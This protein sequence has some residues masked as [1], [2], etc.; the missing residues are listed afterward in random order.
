MGRWQGVTAAVI[1]EDSSWADPL[2]ERM[3][4]VCERYWV[5]TFPNES[6]K[7]F[8][9][10]YGLESPP[11]VP[12]P[13]MR[14]RHPT[15]VAVARQEAFEQDPAGFAERAREYSKQRGRRLHLRTGGWR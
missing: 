14:W 3:L 1:I 8:E 2:Y 11:P 5:C 9:W 7:P 6:A 10:V 13:H 15:V 4:D 12:N